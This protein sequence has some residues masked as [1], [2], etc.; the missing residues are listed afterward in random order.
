VV[1]FQITLDLMAWGS[2]VPTLFAIWND[3]FTDLRSLRF[4]SFS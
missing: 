4:V 1:D 3:Q 2:G